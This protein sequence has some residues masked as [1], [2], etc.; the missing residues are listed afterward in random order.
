MYRE[1]IGLSEGAQGTT[2]HEGKVH[3]CSLTGT[4]SLPFLCLRNLRISVHDLWISLALRSQSKTTKD[5][6][7]QAIDQKKFFTSHPVWKPFAEF[8]I[9]KHQGEWKATLSGHMGT[10]RGQSAIWWWSLLMTAKT[11]SLGIWTRSLGFVEYFL[12]VSH[13]TKCFMCTFSL[14]SLVKEALLSPVSRGRN[15]RREQSGNL[16]KVCRQES[17]I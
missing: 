14:Q 16:S 8:N 5:K 9:E 15:W 1:R 10:R 12:C 6:K 3:R 7:A 17:W 11:V 13:C 2:W 4:A